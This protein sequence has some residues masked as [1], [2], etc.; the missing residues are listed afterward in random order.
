MTAQVPQFNTM[1]SAGCMTNRRRNR[2]YSRSLRTESMF[3]MSSSPPQASVTCE[4]QLQN[5]NPP[6]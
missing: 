4:P 3:R 5:E 1:A 6:V 2:R